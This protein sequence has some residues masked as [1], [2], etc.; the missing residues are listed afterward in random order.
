MPSPKTLLLVA[1]PWLL[2]AVGAFWFGTKSAPKRVVKEVVELVPVGGED[3]WAA[4]QAAPERA[5]PPPAAGSPAQAPTTLRTDAYNVIAEAEEHLRGGFL[6]QRGVLKAFV[7]MG[8]LDESALGAALAE[9]EALDASS[10]SHGLLML[11]VMG[12]WAEFDGAA[13]MAY[14]E[15]RLEGELR[16]GVVANV[17]S[18]WAEGDPVGALEWYRDREASGDL[19]AWLGAAAP[20][21]LAPVFQGLANTD[22][23]AALRAAEGLRTL[24]EVHAAVEGMAA[25]MAAAGKAE[26]LLALSDQLAARQAGAD[27]EVVAAEVRALVVDAWSAYAPTDAARWID[28]AGPHPEKA[29]LAK[30]VALN[31]VRRDPESAIAWMLKRTPPASHGENLAAAVRI[32]ARADPNAAGNW[33]GT[34]AAEGIERDPAL[35]AFAREVVGRDPASA[36]AWA[37]AVGRQ[38]MREGAQDSVFSQWLLRDREAAKAWLATAEGVSEAMRTRWIDR[39]ESTDR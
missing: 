18:S 20:Q 2:T 19:A 21:L 30:A 38:A 1:V 34:A 8:E 6:S 11:A 9:V 37:S 4:G 29:A 33:F 15:E 14:A 39:V 25:S 13:A 17:V 28:A 23:D 36:M 31:W 27:A 16:T 35:A 22:P 10:P 5:S 7:A 26:R 32:W 24:A 12:R 3:P